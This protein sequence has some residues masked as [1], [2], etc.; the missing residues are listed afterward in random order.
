MTSTL[1]QEANRKLGFP[2]DRT[3][4]VAQDL[5]E[6]IGES[7]IE[8]GLITYMRTDSLA[9]SNNAVH[10]TRDLIKDRYGDKYL[11]AKPNKYTSKVHNAQEAHEAIR[12][13]DVTCTP[14][15]IAER[16]HRSGKYGDH[17]KLYELIWKR[18]VACQMTPA[19][20]MLT[21]AK[22]E[23]QV[24]S[25]SSEWLVS[26]EGDRGGGDRT[27]LV[28]QANGKSIQF[29]GFLRAYVEGTDDPEA[30]LED[31]ERVLPQLEKGQQ[32]ERISVEAVGH[33]TRPPARYTDATLVKA[34][35]ER[36]IGRPSTYA[37]ILKTIVDRGYVRKKN[38][39]IIPTFMAFLVTEIL[40]QNFSEFSDFGFTTEMDRVL[41]SIASGQENWKQY[42]HNFF[43]GNGHQPGLKPAVDERRQGIRRPVFEIGLDP[44]T[45][46]PISVQFGRNGFFLV[47]GDLETGATASVP[48][49]MAPADLTPDVAHSLFV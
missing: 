30:A 3:M 34:L 48:E 2:A 36:G 40:S 18:T 9:L 39:E 27:A 8:G 14:E 49:D 11:P 21:S 44:S 37:A 5:Y 19:E 31:Q 1:Q 28:F 29:P 23:V 12:P 35:E 24:P 38:K 4:R 41:D 26:E 22:I 15:V 6:G 20:L 16:L 45:D 13:T 25:P 42:L 33:E 43:F 32:V 47:R 17:A 46:E 7:G 10:Q